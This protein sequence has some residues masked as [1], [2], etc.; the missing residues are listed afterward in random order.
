MAYVGDTGLVPEEYVRLLRDIQQHEL[1]Q[2]VEESQSPT[3]TSPDSSTA[4]TDN[5]QATSPLTKNTPIISSFSTS[6]QDIYPYPLPFHQPG[7]HPPPEQVRSSSGT[8]T[9][10]SQE[11]RVRQIQRE[12]E[13]ALIEEEAETPRFGG[14]KGSVFSTGYREDD[15]DVTPVQGNVMVEIKGDKEDKVSA[16]EASSAEV[17]V[18]KRASKETEAPTL[19]INTQVK[20]ETNPVEE[21]TPAKSTETQT[22]VA[23][24]VKQQP[25]IQKAAAPG[26]SQAKAQ[27]DSTE[28]TVKNP[29]TVEASKVDT[30]VTETSMSTTDSSVPPEDKPNK[31]R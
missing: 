8:P 18:L 6:S 31:T 28:A 17:D 26:D 13:R 12:R 11:E 20:D 5:T 7:D 16:E 1:D 27:P 14:R 29:V 2:S 19:T 23:E 4:A 9:V 3:T 21:V 25:T 10:T 24:P 30:T 15:D 22:E